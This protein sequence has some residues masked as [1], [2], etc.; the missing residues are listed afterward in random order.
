[1]PHV[2]SVD[3]PDQI[4]RALLET[5]GAPYALGSQQVTVACHLGL[6]I[7]SDAYDDLGELI[8]DAHQ[9]LVSARDGGPGIYVVHDETKRG[10]YTT[11]IDEARLYSALENHEFLLH[12]Q[13]IVRA[14][15]PR[16]DRGRGPA[17]LAGSRRHQHRRHVPPRLPA[18][19]REVRPDR[20]RGRLGHRRDLPPGHGLDH[21][22]SGRAAAVRDLQRGRPPAGHAR[23]RRRACC[24][25]WP[26]PGC[27]P[28][29]C[30]STSPRRPSATTARSTWTALRR[31]K[32][33]GVKLG[34]GNF[35][36]GVASLAA[37]RDM[38]LD[39]VRIDRV[40]VQE[41]AMSHEDQAIIRHITNLAHDLGMIAI[42][43]GIE[44]EEQAAVLFT[45]GVDLAQGFLFGRPEPAEQIDA[46]LDPVDPSAVFGEGE[47]D[48]PPPQVGGPFPRPRPRRAA[49]PPPP[50]PTYP[51]WQPPPEPPAP[52][53]APAPPPAPHVEPPA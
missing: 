10:R 13:P 47:T 51:A 21:R 12:W 29:A 2:G 20:A 7:A 53:P 26:S 28:S 33:V 23:L 9:A 42:V 37:M 22:P 50:P 6:A 18:A 52:H 31:L 30:A 35:G 41:L 5:V 36:T 16:A 17:A 15:Q 32:D 1:M 45:L 44:T 49:G 24:G 8:R 11:R 39:L 46:R 48:F 34:L 4:A 19:A 25:S 14:G 40:F 27:R 3:G 38:R 43:E